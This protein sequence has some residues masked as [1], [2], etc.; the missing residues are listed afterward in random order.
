MQER[1][2]RMVELA[3]KEIWPMPATTFKP[4]KKEWDTCSL[5]DEDFKL[6]G[7]SI[8]KYSYRNIETPV[9]SWIDM[10]E[11]VVRYLHNED[12][13]ILPTL[14]SSSDVSANLS[15]YF[16]NN[17]QA[18]RSFLKIDENLYVEKNTNTSMKVS[19]LRR[20]FELFHADPAD[21]VFYLRDSDGPGNQSNENSGQTF[22]PAQEGTNDDAKAIVNAS[23]DKVPESFGKRETRGR[24]DGELLHL[25]SGSADA[26]GKVTTEGFL[27]LQGAKLNETKKSMSGGMARLR[28]K[29]LNEGKIKIWATTE[30]L[31]F[32]SASAAAEFIVGCSA[33]GR[34]LWKNKD[35]KTLKEIEAEK[36]KY[37]I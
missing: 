12:K 33:N 35:G 7:R 29:L 15:K 13:T 8:V 19:I 18:L 1:S 26:L 2:D 11:H 36:D 9:S 32:H 28:E 30:D 14:V 6:E 5:E 10:F 17:P 21:L 31:S 16:S 23:E 37:T 25:S 27:V 34:K 24:N 20:L 4:S 3:K 22:R